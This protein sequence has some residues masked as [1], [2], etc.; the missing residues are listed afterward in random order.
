[1]TWLSCLSLALF[2]L[3]SFPFSA[4]ALPYTIFVKKLK[5]Q[6][7]LQPRNARLHTIL[8]QLYAR[9]RKNKLAA[10]HYNLA[11][12]YKPGYP[13]ALAGKAQLLVQSRSWSKA[14]KALKA[15]LKRHPR[16]PLALATRS[17]WYRLQAPLQKKAAERK[18]FHQRSVFWL[19]KAVKA[20]PDLT[21]YRLR[22]GLILLA[23]RH[24]W[25]AHYHF[26]KLVDIDKQRPCHH[27][28]LALCESFFDN[29][30]KR[31]LTR[32][33][34]HMK[35]CAHPSLQRLTRT[36]LLSLQMQIAKKD[37]QSGQWEAAILR[38]KKA[39]KPLAS[40]TTAHSMLTWWIY[41]KKGCAQAQAYLHPWL[42]Q[43]KASPKLK[44]LIRNLNRLKCRSSV[45]KKTTQKPQT[46]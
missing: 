7:K 19:N 24:Y 27:L 41:S 12:K 30:W 18:K 38:L 44:H 16:H 15:L 26:L 45:A 42:R 17:D 3:L 20:R 23:Q 6:L 32:I 4:Q 22:L 14:D 5:R 40:F 35:T 34:K 9:S 10:H 25:K 21:R 33:Q 13:H 39:L 36:L 31:S 1:L 46:R 11:L 28:G 37:A 8:G 43:K 29:R 2:A